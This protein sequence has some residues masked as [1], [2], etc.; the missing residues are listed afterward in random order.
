MSNIND[1][2]YQR[3]DSTK[4]KAFQHWFLLGLSFSGADEALCCIVMI[5][6]LCWC[7][8][9]F[10][11]VICRWCFHGNLYDAFNLI[12]TRV[13]VL[14][15]RQQL[16]FQGVIFIEIAGQFKLN[17]CYP[18][19]FW[20]SSHTIFPSPLHLPFFPS[21]HPIKVL[22]ARSNSKKLAPLK[23]KNLSTGRCWGGGDEKRWRRIGVP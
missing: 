21:L 2:S 10:D 11:W 5:I 18:T 7:L 4:M 14:L 17:R 16:Q 13:L 20:K 3:L 8:P 12:L 22:G 1:L 23:N 19:C 6:N 15:E 9:H